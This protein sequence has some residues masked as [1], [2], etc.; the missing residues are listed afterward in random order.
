M[1]P[2]FGLMSGFDD[3]AKMT[4]LTLASTAIGDETKKNV[5]EESPSFAKQVYKGTGEALQPRK[6]SSTNSD[7]VAVEEV[8]QAIRAEFSKGLKV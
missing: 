6:T 8:R 1:T 2:P 5:L 3:V 4:T 7:I